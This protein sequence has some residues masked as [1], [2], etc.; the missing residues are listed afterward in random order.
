MAR[1]KRDSLSSGTWC[2][3][4]A[5]IIGV[6]VSDTTAEIRIDTAS[7]IANSRNS[8]PT[9]SPM[10]SSGIS[11]ATSEKVSEMMVKPICLEP[12][13]AACIGESPFSM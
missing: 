8:R 10:N 13:S 9:T 7:V 2:S 5:H 11:T 1:W 6:S 3:R 4:R 12:F